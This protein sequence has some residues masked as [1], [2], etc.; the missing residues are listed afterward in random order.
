ML[1][2]PVIIQKLTVQVSHALNSARVLLQAG[3]NEL[4][5]ASSLLGVPSQQA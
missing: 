2:F 4:D 3:T 1:N 5:R